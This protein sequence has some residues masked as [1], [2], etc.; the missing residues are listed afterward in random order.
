MALTEEQKERIRIN[1]G[2]ALEKKRQK[3]EER[4]KADAEAK[5]AAQSE[6]EAEGQVIENIEKREDKS[7]ENGSEELLSTELEDF[8]VGASEYVTRDEAMRKYCLPPGTL[9]VCATTER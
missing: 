8:E 6:A 9:A 3:A 4:A 5:T 7:A 2:R 1:K